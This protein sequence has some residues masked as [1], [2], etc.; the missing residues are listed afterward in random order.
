MDWGRLLWQTGHWLLLAIVVSSAVGM[1][2][3]GAV[4]QMCGPRTSLETH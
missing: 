2:A 4:V 1:A 3:T